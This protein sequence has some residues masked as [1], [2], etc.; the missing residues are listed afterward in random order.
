M[1]FKVS[2]GDPNFGSKRRTNED[3]I[4][5]TVYNGDGTPFARYDT[6]AGAIGS[7][8]DRQF[9]ITDDGEVIDKEWVREHQLS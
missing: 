2:E 3:R 9:V 4:L 1:W 7:L 6:F 5:Y 8:W